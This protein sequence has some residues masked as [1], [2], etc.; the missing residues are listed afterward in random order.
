MNTPNI[1]TRWL[2]RAVIWVVGL[3][4]PV[5]ADN[6]RRILFL[7]SFNAAL[8][9]KHLMDEETLST[10]NSALSLTDSKECLAVGFELSDELWSKHEIETIFG[11]HTTVSKRYLGMSEIEKLYQSIKA[12]T[13]DWLRYDDDNMRYDVIDLLTR[14]KVAIPY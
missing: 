11:S 6:A 7:S 10:L 14:N 2:I 5:S 13:P 8:V 3:F 12:Y 4:S 1:F 9:A